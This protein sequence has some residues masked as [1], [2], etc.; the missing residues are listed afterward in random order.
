MEFL[1]GPLVRRAGAGQ[2]LDPS[3]II[4]RTERAVSRPGLGAIQ[5]PRR[6]SGGDANRLR[7]VA[8]TLCQLG[9][10]A[11]VTAER[12]LDSSGWV[13]PDRLEGFWAASRSTVHHNPRT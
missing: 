11:R 3:P 13:R 7:L 8:P 4:D 1:A 12:S 6:T 10:P 5:V 9:G 2:T